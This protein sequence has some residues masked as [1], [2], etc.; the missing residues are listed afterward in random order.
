MKSGLRQER[1]LAIVML[2]AMAIATF[3]PAAL[4]DRGGRRYKGDGPVVHSRVITRG[5]RPSYGYAPRYGPGSVYIVRRSSSA[6][7]AI[8]GFLGGLFLGATL[9]NAAPRG[10][11][12]Y[13]PY[14]NESFISLGAYR[15]HLYLHHHPSIVR[16]IE[17]GSGDCVHSYRYD[18]GEWRD[19]EN[20]DNGEDWDR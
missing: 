5:Y 10:Y 19:W 15:Q 4:A 7:P 2:A 14:C 18:G 12:Y 11:D 8:A 9:A 17:V 1:V 16:V 6:G 20:E 3:A 13:D